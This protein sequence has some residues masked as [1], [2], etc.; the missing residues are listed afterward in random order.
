MKYSLISPITGAVIF[1]III[2]L[3]LLLLVLYEKVFTK[4]Y[5]IGNSI[6]ETIVE[7]TTLENLIR[8]IL[9]SWDQEK[10]IST[11]YSD[12]LLEVHNKMMLSRYRK[13]EIK[14]L[15]SVL[16]EGMYDLKKKI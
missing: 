14:V 3:I 13:G 1:G 4:K 6:D 15:D 16:I 8:D 12:N 11:A 5:I 10:I 2:S 7:V 9:L